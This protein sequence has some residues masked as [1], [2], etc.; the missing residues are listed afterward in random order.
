MYKWVQSYA[1]NTFWVLSIY[2]LYSENYIVMG[3]AGEKIYVFRVFAG[4]ENI[5]CDA[6]QA[7]ILSNFHIFI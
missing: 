6:P 3:A 4:L 2:I 1:F 5:F 7:K